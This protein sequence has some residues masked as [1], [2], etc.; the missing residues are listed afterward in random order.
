MRGADVDRG[1]TEE[2]YRSAT[3]VGRGSMERGRF[4]GEEH[5]GDNIARLKINIGEYAIRETASPICSWQ[6]LVA[7]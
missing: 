6:L 3:S 5:S 7:I 1:E 4:E 2:D